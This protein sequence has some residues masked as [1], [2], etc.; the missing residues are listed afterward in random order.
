MTDTNIF[1]A[2][3]AQEAPAAEAPA[4]A[5]TQEAPSSPSAPTIPSGWEEYVGEG[6]KYASVEAAQQAFIHQIKHIST[7]EQENAQ[8]RELKA[9]ESA[10]EELLRE[11]RTSSTTNQQKQTSQGVEVNEDVLSEIIEKKLQQRTQ[12][13]IATENAKSV[14]NTMSAEF[15]DKAEE[16][17]KKIAD[18]S[19]FTVA[20]LDQLASTNPKAVLK[21]AGVNA[22]SSPTPVLQGSVN[23]Q[24]PFAINEKKEPSARVGYNPNSKQL[25]DAW[26]ATKAKVYKDLNIK[27]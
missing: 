25:A 26:A 11:I 8:L 14:V 3:Q 13:Q 4:Q 9:K 12:Q 24:S 10:A 2:D 23:T 6:K 22:K 16:V 20:Q 27:E 17:Y 15:G 21:L 5:T 19:G 1:S 18:E 7:I